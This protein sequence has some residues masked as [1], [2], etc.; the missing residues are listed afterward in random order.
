MKLFIPIITLSLLT[1]LVA[2]IPPPLRLYRHEVRPF[3]HKNRWT[4]K[5]AIS[6]DSMSNHTC[7]T[8][9]T[10]NTTIKSKVECKHN[11]T[12]IPTI[13]LEMPHVIRTPLFSEEGNF[14]FTSTSGFNFTNIGGYDI[15]KQELI[16]IINVLLHPSNYSQYSVRVPRGV[17]LYGPPGT[18][19]TLLAKCLAGQTEIP[20]LATSGTVFVEKYVGVGAARMRELFAF[21]KSNSPCIVFIDELDAIGRHRSGEAGAAN[22][23]RDQT[24]NQLLIEMDGFHSQNDIV[25]IGATNRVDML[26][27][28]LRR[29]GRLDKSFYVGTPDANTRC[30]IID[31]HRTGKPINAS[32]NEIAEMTPGLSGADIESLLNEACLRGIRKNTLPVDSDQL[33]YIIDQMTLGRTASTK[34]TPSDDDL[35]RISVHELGHAFVSLKTRFHGKL[36]AIK[37]ITQSATT[38]GVTIFQPSEI[39]MPTR[40]YLDERI[41]VLFGGRIA[42]ELVFGTDGVSVGATEDLQVVKQLAEQMVVL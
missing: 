31:I 13:T 10:C 17:L 21:A 12:F 40:E 11:S 39:T 22:V 38:A 24:L 20:F 27:E 19:K 29:S 37:I 35:W 5:Q 18:G 9:N 25:V 8:C 14:A 4:A 6:P 41:R 7:R 42:E 33:E 3:P 16:Q 36:K 2:F 26:D 1:D 30:E 23:E 34:A 15:V 28:A 32:T